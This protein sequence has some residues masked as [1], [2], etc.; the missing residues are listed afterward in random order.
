M[1][2]SI[3][4]IGIIL[5]GGVGMRYGAD[6][7]K[8]YCE[9]MGREIISYTVSAFKNAKS[10]DKIIVV[11]DEENSYASHIKELYGLETVPGGKTRN[12]SFKNALSYIE[13]NYPDCEKIIENNA[14]CPM[15][16]SEIADKFMQLLD[17]Y[18]YVNATYK[19]TDALGAYK[20]RVAD[21]EDYYLIQAPDAY[22][23]RQINKYFDPESPLGHPAHQLPLE[24]TE[25]RY[26]GF[27]PNIKITYPEDII[28]AE[29]YMKNREGNQK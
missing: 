2:K 3:K 26:F 21:R 11:V 7:P 24:F 15:I 5:S 12:Y 28:M 22:H 19:I 9:L 17:E 6:K 27:L 25:C 4:N 10:I 8:Q 20:G 13:N 14:A 1:S 18:D 23:F 29:L 16:T